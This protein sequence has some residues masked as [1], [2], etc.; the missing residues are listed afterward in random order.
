LNRLR[1][2]QQNSKFGAPVEKV[3]LEGAKAEALEQAEKAVAQLNELG[4][5]Y[6][7]VE[8][9]EARAPRASEA[10]AGIKRQQKDAPCPICGFKTSPRHDGRAHRT[11]EPK[12]PFTA[13]ELK[14][15]GFEKIE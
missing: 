2:F 4:F 11:Q 10:E 13:A 9:N 15:K 14:E 6:R 5:N 3:G 12:K 1:F 8:G 7:L